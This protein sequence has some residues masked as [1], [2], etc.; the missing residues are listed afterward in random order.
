MLFSNNFEQERGLAY[1]AYVFGSIL[2]RRASAQKK[3]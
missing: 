3:R 2:P 1:E